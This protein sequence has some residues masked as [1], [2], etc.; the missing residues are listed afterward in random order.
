MANKV[1]MAMLLLGT[2]LLWFVPLGGALLLVTAAVGLAI[3]W[4]ADVGQ[5][6]GPGDVAVDLRDLGA[7]P[8]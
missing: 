3:S 7:R 8:D 6:A 5:P 2:G 4:E 1:V